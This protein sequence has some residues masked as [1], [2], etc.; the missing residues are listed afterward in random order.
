MSR[1]TVF[2]L[3]PGVWRRLDANGT[4]E[5]FLGLWEDEI[6][7][8]ADKIRELAD[9]QSPD[10][11]EDKFLPLLGNNVGHVWKDDKSYPDVAISVNEEFPKMFVSRQ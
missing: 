1:Q 8:V 7:Y 11:T 2:E 4:L 9:L 5:R 10:V 3:L 6:G